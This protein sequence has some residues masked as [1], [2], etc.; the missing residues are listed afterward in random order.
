[1]LEVQVQLRRSAGAGTCSYMNN[2]LLTGAVIGCFIWMTLLTV[3][4]LAQPQISTIGR[5]TAFGGKVDNSTALTLFDGSRQGE[6]LDIGRYKYGWTM[7]TPYRLE[8]HPGEEFSVSCYG[9]GCLP[10]FQVRNIGDTE[11]AIWI[12]GNN[13]IGSQF[14][15]IKFAIGSFT[16]GGTEI[17]RFEK[18]GSL[19]IHGDLSV[20]GKSLSARIEA[21][22]ARLP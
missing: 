16:D 17:A 21:I 4:I 22:E 7:M 6:F 14:G 9:N 8:M 15:P 10:R 20:G 3:Y 13:I 5:H 1:M 11:G 12:N 2:R 18:D 19:V